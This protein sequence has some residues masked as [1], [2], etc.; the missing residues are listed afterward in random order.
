MEPHFHEDFDSQH[1]HSKSK[2]R[3]KLL[4]PIKNS[5]IKTEPNFINSFIFPE[6][7]KEGLA[8][9]NL[10]CSPPENLL[11][12]S[13]TFVS[14]YDILNN[15]K[16]WTKNFDE[17]FS[18]SNLVSQ[19]LYHNIKQKSLFEN[20]QK[21]KLKQSNG[22]L[23]STFSGFKKKETDNQ[24]KVKVYVN[25]KDKD[26]KAILA[27][28]K[29][30]ETNQEEEEDNEKTQSTKPKNKNNGIDSL[31]LLNLHYKFF[32]YKT[33][34]TEWKPENREGATLTYINGKCYLFGGKASRIHNE[35]IELETSLIFF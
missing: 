16:E 15:D 2:V 18:E 30:I 8:K 27:V 29:L 9:Y 35:I 12:P 17:P 5:Y 24:K 23:F 19:Q 7:T 31:D 14:F 34:N 22:E 33:N 21:N 32:W 4:K 3:Y 6:K 11:D 13:N 28:K 25:E 10:I 26:M 20:Q 1:S